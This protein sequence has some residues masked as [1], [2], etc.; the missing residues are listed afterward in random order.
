MLPSDGWMLDKIEAENRH[1]KTLPTFIILGQTF[2]Y[3]VNNFCKN[4]ILFKKISSS[5]QEVD[6]YYYYFFFKQTTLK[7]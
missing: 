7:L 5:K 2:L 4:Y 1:N 6:Y 3:T